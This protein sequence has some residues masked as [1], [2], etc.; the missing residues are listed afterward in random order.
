MQ[1]NNYWNERYWQEKHWRYG[2]LLLI[3]QDTAGDK[4]LWQLFLPECKPPEL[5]T[6]NRLQPP[7]CSVEL[8]QKIM[9]VN[10]ALDREI[11]PKTAGPGKKTFC[12]WQRFTPFETVVLDHL[13]RVPAGKVISY[14]SLAERSGYPRAARAV[15]SLMARN[16]FPLFYPCHRVIRAA[17]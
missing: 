6:G 4:G 16:P 9:M 8:R 3:W 2:K 14:G 13:S 5:P 17:G 10:D 7:A 12:G 1:T 15:G 11:I